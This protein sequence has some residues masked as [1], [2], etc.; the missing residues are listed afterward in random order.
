MQH[1]ARR[2]RREIDAQTLRRYYANTCWRKDDIEREQTEGVKRGGREGG[3]G[4][5]RESNSYGYGIR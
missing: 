5:A 2:T 3:E 1:T 4:V